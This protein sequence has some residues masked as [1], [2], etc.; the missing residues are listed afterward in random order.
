MV[1]MT[2]GAFARDKA[3]WKKFYTNDVG[4]EFY[5][6]VYQ[7]NER[8]DETAVFEYTYG[9]YELDEDI[10]LPNCNEINQK[11]YTKCIEHGAVV[12]KDG[13]WFSITYYLG[14]KEDIYLNKYYS[15]AVSGWFKVEE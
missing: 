14:Y 4:T 1:L 9:D 12:L 11:V 2:F 3:G 8:Y 5:Y 10:Y 7:N 13:D 6:N 15:F